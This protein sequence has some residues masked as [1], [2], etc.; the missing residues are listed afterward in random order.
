[1][2][3]IVENGKALLLRLKNLDSYL[4]LDRW[5]RCSLLL[6]TFLSFLSDG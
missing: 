6:V 4:H 2:V 5:V 1:M 3:E